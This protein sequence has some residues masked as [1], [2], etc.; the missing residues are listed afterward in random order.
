MEPAAENGGESE[1]E[2]AAEKRK[3]VAEAYMEKMR[4]VSRREDWFGSVF[5]FNEKTR[6][7]TCLPIRILRRHFQIP[8]SL[9]NGADKLVLNLVDFVYRCSNSDKIPKGNTCDSKH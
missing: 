4:A 3:R 2:T 5:C 9:S 7:S 8:L 1:E 6:P